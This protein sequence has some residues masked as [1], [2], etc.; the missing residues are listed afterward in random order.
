MTEFRQLFEDLGYENVKTLLQS[1]NV[2]FDS[3]RALAKGATA[4]IE[5]E[6]TSRFGF[7]GYFVVLDAKAFRAVASANPLLE[8]GD[9]ESKLTVTFLPDP[10]DKAAID[11][12][13]AGALEP[14]VVQLGSDAVYSWCPLGISNSKIRPAFWKQFGPR[15]TARNVKTV[16]KLL[17]ILDGRVT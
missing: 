14:E 11:V 7:P 3:P 9:D 17:A 12:P 6:F 13:D 8:V 16:N 5:R 2:V 1:G 10:V 15:A 4:A